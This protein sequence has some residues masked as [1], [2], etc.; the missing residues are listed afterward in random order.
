MWS[1]ACTGKPVP[2][3]GLC[4]WFPLP[5]CPIFKRTGETD[6]HS[7][8]LS[9]WTPLLCTLYV[10][11][12]VIQVYF[13][14][15]A[16]EK[17]NVL[18]RVNHIWGISKR[19]LTDI[20]L[21][22]IICRHVKGLY[23]RRYTKLLLPITQLKIQICVTVLLDETAETETFGVYST[24]KSVCPFYEHAYAFKCR[25]LNWV[26]DAPRWGVRLCARVCVCACA[27]LLTCSH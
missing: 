2:Q 26:E 25:V 9:D 15:G 8:L 7:V 21:K 6:A 14:C 11:F 4:F 17:S 13:C 19:L 24:R 3:Q 18:I 16:I 22:T 5:S 10:R 23:S 20:I 27:P 12:T 1:I